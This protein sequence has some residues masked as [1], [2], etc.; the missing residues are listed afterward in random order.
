[1]LRG[2]LNQTSKRGHLSQVIESYF[3]FAAEGKAA[4]TP[5]AAAAAAQHATTE[6]SDLHNPYVK[7]GVA[8]GGES[9]V[10]QPPLSPT[11]QQ[12]YQYV[13]HGEPVKCEYL[14]L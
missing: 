5:A 7:E 10:Q 6:Q 4:E 8:I 3:S 11:S 1:M 13:Q 9:T 12:Q 2:Y 14:A